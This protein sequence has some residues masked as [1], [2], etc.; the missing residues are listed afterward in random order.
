MRIDRWY[1]LNFANEDYLLIMSK[2]LI[3][4][5]PN[6]IQFYKN[7]LGNLF[8]VDKDMQILCQISYSVGELYIE[9]M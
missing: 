8:M 1:E 9:E 6:G 2:N 5:L 3:H 4:T 7:N